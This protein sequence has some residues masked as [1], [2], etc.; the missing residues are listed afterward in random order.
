MQV[1]KSEYFTYNLLLDPKR[2][3][4]PK[5]WR[6]YRSLVCSTVSSALEGCLGTSPEHALDAKWSITVALVA[7]MSS[8][9]FFSQAIK[10]TVLPPLHKQICHVSYWACHTPQKTHPRKQK[11]CEAGIAVL[12]EEG[13]GRPLAWLTGL[14]QPGWSSLRLIPG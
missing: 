13:A 11:R 2:T 12:G 6:R 9:M 8:G 4:L 3:L 1:W 14:S 7:L 5:A 10:R